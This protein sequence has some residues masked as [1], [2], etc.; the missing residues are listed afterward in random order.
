MRALIIPAFCGILLTACAPQTE[1]PSLEAETPP[2][3]QA[4]TQPESP[5]VAEIAEPVAI[6][7]VA[8]TRTA[9]IDWTQARQDFA[10]RESDNSAMV[11]VA[12]VGSPAVPVLL[13][14]EPVTVATTGESSLD[15]R[16]MDDG[17]FAIRKGDIYDMIINGTDRLVV[18]PGDSGTVTDS[19]LDFEETLTGAQ[20]SFSRYGASY[21]VEFM[22]KDPATAMKG[23]CVSEDEALAEVENLLIAGT[24]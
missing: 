13:P 5:T 22:C 20:V 9:T 24:R 4:E 7:S 6:G 21:L 10:S 15:F 8:E 12:S 1:A 19:G 2:P 16:P 18:R 3:V 11:Q 17:Y 14:D 23:S